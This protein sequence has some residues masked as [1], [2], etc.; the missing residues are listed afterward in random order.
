MAPT[1]TIK[2]IKFPKKSPPKSTV[3]P[4]KY[5]L[6]KKKVSKAPKA[7]LSLP[8]HPK[9][10]TRLPAAVQTKL[11]MP[12]RL[13]VPA[14]LAPI[15]II[16]KK[17][18]KI[19]S[20]LPTLRSPKAISPESNQSRSLS[21]NKTPSA[22]SFQMPSYYIQP[23]HLSSITPGCIVWLPA[24]V[25]ILPG[26]Y[27][28]KKLHALAFDHPAIILSSPKPLEMKS[29]VEFAVVSSPFYSFSFPGAM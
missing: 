27:M 26:A 12:K 23:L 16:A 7:K 1:R 15:R 24:A 8:A 29:V 11:S 28:D 3:Q 18:S 2:K 14:P 17:P 25:S 6:P 5:K 10:A 20:L 19:P 21:P 22:S 4:I 9:M 13:L